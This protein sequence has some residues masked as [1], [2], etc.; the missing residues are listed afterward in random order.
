MGKTNTHTTSELI[1]TRE[2]RAMMQGTVMLRGDDDYARMRRIWNRA[3]ENQP[4]LIAVC[5]TST[6]V[7]AAVRVAR[8]HNL[9]FSVRGGGHDWT[10]RALCTDGLVIDL[11]QMREV[12][13]DPRSRVAIV[14]GGASAKDVAAAAGAHG[15]VAAL[16]YRCAASLEG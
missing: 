4:T 12:V 14:S 5:E 9:P 6:D 16:R 8:R 13:A 3:V 10:G 7:Q 1:A 2:L 15:L 11:S